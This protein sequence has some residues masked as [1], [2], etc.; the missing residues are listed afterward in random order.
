MEVV[1][2]YRHPVMRSI[3]MG[4]S[5]TAWPLELTLLQHTGSSKT[6]L[7]FRRFPFQESIDE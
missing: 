6:H 3:S 2:M 5:C 1:S 7:G 4:E